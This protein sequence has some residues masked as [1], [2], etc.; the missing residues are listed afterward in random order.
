VFGR[1]SAQ[2]QLNGGKNRIILLEAMTMNRTLERA[3]IG[4]A[5]LVLVSVAAFTATRNGVI[6]SDD[7]RTV[8]VKARAQYIAATE[9]QDSTL[10]K[11]YDNLG[12][13]YP[14]GVYWCCEGATISGP[15][16]P[17]N[18]E[19]WDAVAFP[20]K[21][22]RSVTKINLALGYLGGTNEVIVGLNNDAAGVPGTAIKTWK[23]KNLPGGGTCCALATITDQSGIAVSRGV[24]YWIT[25]TTNASDKDAF[26]FWNV[27]DTD[28]V[29]PAPSAARCYSTGGQCRQDN[30]KWVAVPQTPGLALEV[31]GQ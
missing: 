23:V 27:N 8:M 4:V 6:V 19:W 30:G 7:G 24:Q 20:P 12:S 11:I 17:G 13:A 1:Q 3:I 9:E 22:D 25:V 29:D 28:Q 26:L 31:L 2:L 14:K 16:S 15:D 21:A 18:V 5:V 10:V